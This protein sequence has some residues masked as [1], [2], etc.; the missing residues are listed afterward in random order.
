MQNPTLWTRLKAATRGEVSADTLEAYRR[1]SLPV[2]ELLESVEAARRVGESPWS[3]PPGEQV[4]MVC[5]WNAFVLQRLGTAFLEAD[6][7]DCPD[8]VGF[9]PP[10][11]SE[12]VTAF[13]A[14]V[15]RWLGRAGRAATDPNIR[16]DGHLPAPL[17]RWSDLGPCPRSHLRGMMDAMEAIRDHARSAVAFLGETPPNDP[18]HARQFHT[19]RGL[20]AV[21][22]TKAR[23]A[24]DLH[25]DRLTPEIHLLVEPTIKEAIELFHRV[26][27]LAGM[28]ELVH[29]VMLTG[30]PLQDSPKASAVGF[31]LPPPA[32]SAFLKDLTFDPWCL[33]DTKARQTLQVDAEAC[34]AI[35]RL[36]RH[37]PD[38]RAT[39]ALHAEV[40]AA[41]K[42]RRVVEATWPG[43]DRLGHFFSCPWPTVYE[44]TRRMR[45]GGQRLKA[46]QKF[47]L[48]VSAEGVEQGH[49]FRREIKLGDFRPASEIQYGHANH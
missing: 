18:D 45:I 43:G 9:V 5:A 47:V 21:A 14:P 8:T 22:D 19:I 44:T 12:Q 39:L 20:F 2:L 25:G 26:G 42:R 36:W 10:I 49:L 28:P 7:L 24:E 15:E 6:Y 29:A 41:V 13:F 34:A 4:R 46:H 1:A 37:D 33:T 48:D 23:Y 40:Q 31:D 3:L 30:V 16:L 27:Q 35:E 17:P 11:T 38:P 32:A